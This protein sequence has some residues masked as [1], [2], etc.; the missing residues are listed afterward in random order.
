LD[1]VK[2]AVERRKSRKKASEDAGESEIEIEPKP[3][4][5]PGEDQKCLC[6]E[7]FGGIQR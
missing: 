4:T 7:T 3:L 6:E 2:E 5:P 1:T